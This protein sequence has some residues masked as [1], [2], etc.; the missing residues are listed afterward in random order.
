M[1]TSPTQPRP[2]GDNQHA[3]QLSNGTSRICFEILGTTDG[4]SID[5]ASG[6]PDFH[7]PTTWFNNLNHTKFC[8]GSRV[9]P[10]QS[11]IGRV[12]WGHYTVAI[13]TEKV[14]NSLQSIR[15]EMSSLQKT[16]TWTF[17]TRFLRFL[18]LRLVVVELKSMELG[19]KNWHHG[20]IWI[21]LVGKRANS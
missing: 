1:S 15:M 13:Y 2:S 17:Q 6:F 21:S 8:K 14:R 3:L 4:P 9:P 20:G 11:T 5:E 18:L 16:W 12:G 19:L 10:S 7:M